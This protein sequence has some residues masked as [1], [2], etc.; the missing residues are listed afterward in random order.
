MTIS[1][2]TIRRMREARE[3]TLASGM[4]A[5]EAHADLPE[6]PPLPTQPGESVAIGVTRSE[7]APNKEAAAD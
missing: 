5:E 6:L 4:T 3:Q 7:P 2:E 1:E